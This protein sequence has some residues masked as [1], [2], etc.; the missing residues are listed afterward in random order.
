MASYKRYLCIELMNG[1]ITKIVIKAETDEE[2]K[3]KLSK[4]L[5]KRVISSS[6]QSDAVILREKQD[7]STIL[8]SSI[9]T[10]QG[11]RRRKTFFA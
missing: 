7:T 3:K 5:I 1:D 10:Y 11:K 6:T 8:H 2:Y 9:N 4:Y